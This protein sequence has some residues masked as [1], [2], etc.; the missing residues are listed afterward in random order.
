M[1]SAKLSVTSFASEEDGRMTA[2]ASRVGV[3]TV[4]RQAGRWKSHTEHVLEHRARQ[5]HE[6]RGASC[7]WAAGCHM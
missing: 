5:A 1:A 3:L 4:F 7:L 6:K 2:H